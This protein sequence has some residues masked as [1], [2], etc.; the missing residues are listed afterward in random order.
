MLSFQDLVPTII[1]AI[2]AESGKPVGNGRVPGNVQSTPAATFAIVYQLGGNQTETAHG[3]VSDM[4]WV[5]IQVTS[6][7]ENSRQSNW[8]ADQ[9]RTA[10]L[11][12]TG[13]DY[14]HALE[15]DGLTICARRL[16]ELATT[17]FFEG[18]WQTVERFRFLV[19]E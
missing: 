7:G 5:D 10:L 8:M 15:P 12:K 18:V 2:E 11:G 16:D 1:T 14:T 19:T 4:T 6:A 13:N 17:S 9:A 3:F